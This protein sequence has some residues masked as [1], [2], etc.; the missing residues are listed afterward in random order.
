MHWQPF[1]VGDKKL[2]LELYYRG[3]TLLEKG[4][5]MDV[6]TTGMYISGSYSG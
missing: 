6:P 3:V 4:I 2:A 5:G 1:Y